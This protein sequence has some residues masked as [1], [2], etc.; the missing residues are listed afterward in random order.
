MST[1]VISRESCYPSLPEFLSRNSG[2]SN[3]QEKT[4]NTKTKPRLNK[5]LSLPASTSPLSWETNSIKS[6]AESPK[7][8]L[9]TN[10]NKLIS[11]ASTLPATP[12]ESPFVQ[13]TA[14]KWHESTDHDLISSGRCKNVLK[15]ILDSNFNCPSQLSS[16]S[17]MLSDISA[18][19]YEAISKL[20]FESKRIYPKPRLTFLSDKSLLIAEMALPLHEVGVTFLGSELSLMGGIPFDKCLVTVIVDTNCRLMKKLDGRRQVRHVA[21]GECALSQNADDLHKKFEFEVASN[22]EVELVVKLK[23]DEGNGYESPDPTSDAYKLLVSPKFNQ[24]SKTLIPSAESHL[25]LD[26]FTYLMDT[27]APSSS[28]VVA[29][30]TWCNINAVHFQVWVRGNTPIDIDVDDGP[31]V[32]HGTLFPDINMENVDNMIKRGL[33]RMCD[34]L[35][36]LLEVLD[37]QFDASPIRQHE[38]MFPVALH[39][40]HCRDNFMIAA[41]ETAHARYIEWYHAELDRGVKRSLSDHDSDSNYVDSGISQG[42]NDSGNDGPSSNTRTRKKQKTD[43][44]FVAV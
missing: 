37:P 6:V 27:S 9:L 8:S 19:E 38:L 40:D 10:G 7:A 12:A 13:L 39:W 42:D 34:R 32:A 44:E 1:V 22:P 41:E 2:R 35:A 5:S 4:V 15:F 20:V 29:G 11:L 31:D 43:G 23:V 17:R 16:S 28:V 18:D 30:H 21:L 14:T 24:D 36:A 3:S 25:S 33:G 26:D